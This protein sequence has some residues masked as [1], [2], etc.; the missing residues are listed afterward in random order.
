MYDA[1]YI[2]S[3]IKY[4]NLTILPGYYNNWELL[5]EAN[6]STLDSY[7]GGSIGAGRVSHAVRI[8]D[9]LEKDTLAPIE[10]LVEAP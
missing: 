5:T 1:V 9:V 10:T 6:L 3:I 2:G 8:T 4:K 7:A